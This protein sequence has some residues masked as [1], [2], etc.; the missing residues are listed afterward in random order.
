[1]TSQDYSGFE[2]IIPSVLEE[3]GVTATHIDMVSNS[4]N[5]VFRIDTSDV[6]YALRFHRP[7][8]HS[9]DELNSEVA[10]HE[11]VHSA[12]L[13]VPRAIP[14]HDGEFY[15]LR[16]IPGRSKKRFIGLNE[17]MGGEVLSSLI[18]NTTD[19]NIQRSHYRELGRI[20]AALHGAAESWQPPPNFTRHSLDAD[21]LLGEKPFWGRFWD[22]P[23]AS[24]AQRQTLCLARDHLYAFVSGLDRATIGYGVMHADLHPANIMVEGQQ[25]TVFDFDDA[26]YGWF[27]YDIATAL[28]DAWFEDA[29][30]ESFKDEMIAGYTE[31][32]PLN[33]PF[34]EALPKFLLIRGLA[35]IGWLD[36]RPEN[37]NR[38]VLPELIEF[39]CE[40]T[41]VI[42]R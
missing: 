15:V 23:A 12:G 31:S 32:R 37:E 10:I 5:I 33:E 19:T 27:P 35:F 13:S 1:M 26:A 22:T 11:L 25:L 40:H 29:N 4:E 34:R 24:I 30:Y 28:F 41:A 7:G 6:S 20:T 8:Y 16:Q 42:C 18:E 3:W 17:W 38:K 2:E 14:T 39:A 9:L 36:A 21:G